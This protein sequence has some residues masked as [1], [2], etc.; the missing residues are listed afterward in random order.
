MNI[1]KNIIK[2]VKQNWKWLLIILGFFV[3]FIAGIIIAMPNEPSG[4]ETPQEM[5]TNESALQELHTNNVTLWQD[6]VDQWQ[7]LERK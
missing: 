2:F 1:L 5:Y 4:I 3:G 6:V 7:F